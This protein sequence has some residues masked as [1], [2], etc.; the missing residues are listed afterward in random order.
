MLHMA[1]MNAATNKN[2]EHE[3]CSPFLLMRHDGEKVAVP[4]LDPAIF[5]SS[6]AASHSGA[7]QIQQD[8][9]VCRLLPASPGQTG[10]STSHRTLLP[11][12]SGAAPVDGQD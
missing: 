9:P 6:P 8:L 10:C 4:V 1:R 5:R 11:H 3:A 12:I 2:G 7:S